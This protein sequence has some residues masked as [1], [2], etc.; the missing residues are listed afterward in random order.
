EEVVGDVRPVVAVRAVVVGGAPD[1]D[2]GVVAEARG[3]AHVDAAETLVH[4]LGVAARV[5]VA[6]DVDVPVHGERRAVPGEEGARLGRARV[7]RAG[8][9]EA[10]GGERV[11]AVAGPV[12]AAL[13]LPRSPVD[14]R[15][16]G[17]GGAGRVGGDVDLAGGV[18]VDA[19]GRSQGA[20]PGRRVP[21]A[22]ARLADVEAREGRRARPDVGV[23]AGD[24]D[25]AA[26]D[27]LAE[28]VRAR[29]DARA[30]AEAEVALDVHG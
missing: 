2:R 20:G 24:V 8:Q 9:V 22:V 27:E 1:A 10:R 3:A 15:R 25:P 26:D 13:L 16:V 23:V 18:L 29:L 14:R 28:V 7:R 4:E 21:G 5:Q 12:R 30:L 6:V 17:E 11:P 19:S